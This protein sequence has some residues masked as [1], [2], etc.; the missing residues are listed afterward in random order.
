MLYAAMCTIALKQRSQVDMVL[1]DGVSLPIP[2]L[3]FFGVPVLFYCHFPDKLLVQ[4]R[5]QMSIWKVCLFAVAADYQY[6]SM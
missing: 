2:L 1:L 5:S 4:N 6:V 3:K